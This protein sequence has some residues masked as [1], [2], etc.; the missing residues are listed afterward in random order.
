MSAQHDEPRAWE[1]WGHS[2]VVGGMLLLLLAAT[3]LIAYARLGIFNA[4]AS[5]GI[6]AVKA[7]LVALIFMKL[8]RAP[9]LLILA[10][11]QLGRPASP[12][13]IRDAGPDATGIPSRTPPA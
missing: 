10:H 3:I 12:P 8:R 2:V 11:L 13:E 4:V 9:A 1:V 5:F 6:A 7:G